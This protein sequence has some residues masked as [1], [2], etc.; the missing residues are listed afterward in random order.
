VDPEWIDAGHRT[1][2]SYPALL[3]GHY[4]FWV[5][6]SNNDGV[7]NHTG[8][9]IEIVVHAAWWA[10]WWFRTIALLVAAV[11]LVTVFQYRTR[12]IHERTLELEAINASLSDQMFKRRQAEDQRERLIPELEAR[13]RELERFT[14][15]VSHDLKSPLVTITGFLGILERDLE[16]EDRD[17]VSRDV[18]QIRTAAGRMQQL[19]DELL[20][21]SRAGRLVNPP[22]AIDLREVAQ[23][24]VALLEGQAADRGVTITI[25]DDMPV[26]YGDR[27]RLLQVF[28]N[29]IQNGIKFLGDQDH[30][31][32]EI[33]GRQQGQEW[34]ISVR[35]NGTGINPAYHQKIFGLFEQLTPD[36]EG[37]GIG[38]ALVQRIVEVHGGRVWVESEGEGTGSLFSFTLPLGRPTSAEWRLPSGE[39]AAPSGSSSAATG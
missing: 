8:A 4:T 10:T 29:L 5:R 31:R 16:E 33:R 35:D 1:F 37:T 27:V 21:L 11:T 19:L 20:D 24:A 6:G 34:V 22:T 28:Q 39:S 14:Y 13:N 15:T 3:P 25:E 36:Q 23:E 26:V 32:V 7:W 12:R 9:T 30:P 2:A 18:G 17:G 38:L